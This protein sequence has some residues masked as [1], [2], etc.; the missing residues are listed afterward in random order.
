MLQVHD[1]RHWIGGYA[2]KSW[3]RVKGMGADEHAY[4]F[5]LT[6][7][8]TFKVKR[9]HSAMYYHPR[10]GPCFGGHDLVTYQ[11]DETT[12]A[13]GEA[14]DYTCGNTDKINNLTQT[15]CDKSGVASFYHHQ[16]LV[17]TVTS[18]N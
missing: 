12:T 6:T 16:L 1:N 9:S 18:G 4:I 3:S 14:W 7:S 10:R 17:W 2:S 11:D 5:N 13:K 8:Q 15:K